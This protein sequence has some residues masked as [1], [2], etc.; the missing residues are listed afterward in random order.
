MDF[1]T[2]YDAIPYHSTPFSETHPG[3]LAVIGRL[4]GLETPEARPAA[5]GDALIKRLGLANIRIL[6]ANLLELSDDLGKFDYIRSPRLRWC[7][8]QKSIPIPCSKET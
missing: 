8:W 3:N 4:F 6:N 7:T 5:A 2:D 1:A